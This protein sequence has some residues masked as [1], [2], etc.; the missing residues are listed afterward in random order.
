MRI[1]STSDSQGGH[2]GHQDTT[3]N[4]TSTVPDVLANE[5]PCLNCTLFI[6]IAAVKAHYTMASDLRFNYLVFAMHESFGIA[7]HRI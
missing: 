4:L 5:M 3:T 1:S 7:C 2:D 6:Q